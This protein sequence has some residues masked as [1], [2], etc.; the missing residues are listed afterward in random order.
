MTITTETL[1]TNTKPSPQSVRT[2][3]DVERTGD[4][5]LKELCQLT[6]RRLQ[7]DIVEPLLRRLGFKNVLDTS[8]TSEHGKDLIATKADEFGGTV[9]CAIQIKRFKPSA[10][11]GSQDSFG[12][13]LDQLRQTVQEPVIDPTT[14]QRR[15]PDRCLF[16]APYA[17]PPYVRDAFQKRLDEPVFKI[18]TIVDGRALCEK[19]RDYLPEAVNCF[20]RE[21][22]YRLRVSSHAGTIR[23]SSVA[24]ELGQP[25]ELEAIYVDVTLGQGTELLQRLASLASRTSPEE[26]TAKHAE[27]SAITKHA[28][29]P[30]IVAVRENDAHLFG[31]AYLEWTGSAL[32]ERGGQEPKTGSTEMMQ[33]DL[34]PLVKALHDRLEAQ[35]KQL[36]AISLSGTSSAEC[37]QIARGAISLERDVRTLQQ[38]AFITQYC[39]FIARPQLTQPLVPN[40]AVL[41]SSSLLKIPTSIYVLGPPGTGKT[42]LLR[43]LTQLTANEPDGPLPIFLPLITVTPPSYHGLVEACIQQMTD[44]GYDFSAHGKSFA[45][46]ARGGSLRLC[47][48]GLDEAGFHAFALM[49]AID[50]FVGRNRKTQVILSCRDTFAQTKG[51]ESLAYWDGALTIR[52]LPFSEHQL[53]AFV[54]KWF[55]AEPSARAGLLQWLEKNPHMRRAAATPLIAALLCSLYQLKTDMPAT[56]VDL[57]E[58]R[59]ELL[60]GRWE[61]AKG[62]HP[63]RIDIR[64]RY[65]FFLMD[66]AHAMHEQQ[67]RACTAR[68]ATQV[69]G[70]LYAK[71][72]HA[73]PG[74]MVGDCVQRGVLELTALGKYSFG[75]LTY[76]EYLCAEYLAHHNPTSFILSKLTDPWWGKVFEFY[77]ARKQDIGLLLRE[78][79]HEPLNSVK[80]ERLRKLAELAP[81]TPRAIIPDSRGS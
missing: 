40:L 2:R 64:N 30:L 49:E 25:L 81:L 27:Q 80:V 33:V 35:F 5:Q 65:R 59:F 32:V 60:L 56:E 67:S 29:D 45:S 20:S 3:R 72:F 54:E 10:K 23:E 6:E 28:K 57:Y 58:K 31:R 8:G 1:P 14:N 71:G 51:D 7:A 47:L 61:K 21:V 55:P 26:T 77:A 73:S 63:L 78:A 53:T 16:I 48:D 75:H 69:A 74:E 15:V 37:G 44:D 79:S 38:Q 4:L 39:P 34:N 24:F 41:S 68:E 18:L 50:E 66:L 70:R 17:I 43:R 36:S 76:Q 42:T 46:L 22:Q 62:I 52:L 19:I 12:R 13:L 9:L 11:A